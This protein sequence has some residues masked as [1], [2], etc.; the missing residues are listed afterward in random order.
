MH[1]WKEA[2]ARLNQAQRIAVLTGAGVSKPSGIPTFRDAAGLWRG[3]NP[4]E[5]ASPQAYARDPQKVWGWYAWRYQQVCQAQPNP[6]HLRLVELEHRVGED[7]LLVTQ[8]VDGL[9]ARAGS[10]RLVELH[11]NLTQGRCEVC[12]H[13]FALPAPE[14]FTPP[15]QCPRCGARA[16]PD[17]VWFGER[18]P[19]GAFETAEQAFRDCE[20]ALI[21]GTSGEVEPAAGLGRL[22]AYSG[23]YLVEINPEPTPLSSLASSSLRMGAVEGLEALM[24]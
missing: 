9:H 22:A 4:E 14:T 7:F 18:L 3:F 6:A 24:G 20:V 19:P 23:A 15:P 5:Y 8:N 11:G 2:R 17:V 10:Q 13:R 1:A 12:G 16:R 21:L